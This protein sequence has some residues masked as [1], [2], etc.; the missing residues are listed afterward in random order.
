[1]V[2]SHKA[3]DVENLLQYIAPLKTDTKRIK[4]GMPRTVAEI[5]RLLWD[6]CYWSNFT[7]YTL[8][9]F[10]ELGLLVST[11]EEVKNLQPYFDP[12]YEPSLDQ[13]NLGRIYYMRI[14]SAVKIRDF[15]AGTEI[16]A[17]C[18]NHL[19]HVKGVKYP[20]IK[21]HIG[22]VGTFNSCWCYSK[23]YLH[24]FICSLIKRKSLT[25]NVGSRQ[26]RFPGPKAG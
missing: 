10:S 9:Q 6:D 21:R 23:G 25:I 13:N 14:E 2:S 22:H 4:F 26:H 3:G 7:A 8:D 24:K 18:N 20:V 16:K 15:L 17:F 12:S 19:W 5:E 11:L 1:M